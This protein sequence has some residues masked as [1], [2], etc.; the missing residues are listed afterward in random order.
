V[1]TIEGDASSAWIGL[2]RHR[3]RAA[4]A[5]VEL[6]R[7]QEQLD[8]DALEL[9]A[10]HLGAAAVRLAEI[11]GRSVLGPVGEDVLARVFARFCIGK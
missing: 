9:L 4:E 6:A 3:D 11:R 8:G 5:V 1:S 2:A 7:A 10:F